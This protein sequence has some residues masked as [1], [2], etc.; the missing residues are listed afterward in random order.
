[1]RRSQIGSWLTWLP[2]PLSTQRRTRIHRILT[3]GWQHA[4]LA[5]FRTG[6]PDAWREQCSEPGQTLSE[7]AGSKKRILLIVAYASQLHSLSR[8]VDREEN[9]S[10]RR[11]EGGEAYQDCWRK[12]A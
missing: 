1:M 10:S 12:A 8:E 6:V 7:V 4:M 2:L 5:Q 3:E 11:E 9:V